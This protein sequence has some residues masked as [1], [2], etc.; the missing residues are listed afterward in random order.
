MLWDWIN[1]S[2][3]RSRAGIQNMPVSEI[4]PD[5]RFYAVGDIHGR[6]DLLQALLSRMDPDCPLVFVGDYI[7]RGSY[8][9][10]V[11]R[12]LRHLSQGTDRQVVCLMGNHEAMLL[13][14]LDDPE[15]YAPHWL[16]NG[17]AHTLASF[18]V[19]GIDENLVGETSVAA[20]DQLRR[21]MGE[22]LIAWLRARPLTWSSGN[23]TAVHAAL[24]PVLAVGDQP[25][26]VCLWGHPKFFDQSR[27]DGQW[28]VHGHTIVES[29][30]VQ[31]GIVS[32]DT[33]AFF[34]GRLTAAEILEGE[35]RFT[36]TPGG[37]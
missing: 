6:L 32:I 21:A 1:K 8:S 20:A 11:L 26:Q 23:V 7:D 36:S 14:F 25:H 37:R 12:H 17:G 3:G 35:V 31:N 24:D 34:S 15:Q 33:G 18:G 13:N 9:A 16:Q 5:M 28:V 19:T 29:S 2:L 4:A 27:T 10:E 22:D 30:R